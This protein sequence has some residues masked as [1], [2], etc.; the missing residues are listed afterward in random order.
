MSNSL[1]KYVLEELAEI[2]DCIIM[3]KKTAHQL[4][5]VLEHQFIDYEYK[6][7]HDLIKRMWAF[8]SLIE[9]EK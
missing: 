2:N 7:V 5:K 6:E 8:V 4:L 3:N 9:E 1:E